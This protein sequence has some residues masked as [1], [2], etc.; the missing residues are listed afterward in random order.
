MFTRRVKRMARMKRMTRLKRMA[1]LNGWSIAFLAFAAALMGGCEYPYRSMRID[2]QEAVLQSD[3]GRAREIFM[4]CHDRKPNDAENLHDVGAMSYV[5]G[6]GRF[7]ERNAPAGLRECDRAIDFYGR[8]IMARP[9]YPAAIMGR[10]AAFELKGQF[11]KALKQAEWASRFVGPMARQYI[12]LAREHEDRGDM[13]LA[14][15]RYR[16]AV[17]LE[18]DNPEAHQAYGEFLQR[19]N[20]HDEASVE[21]REAERLYAMKEMPTPPSLQG[22]GGEPQP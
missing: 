6:E 13:D 3:Y 8:A 18:P 20:L 7:K 2:G 15:L 4:K 21:L 10:T 22:Q 14:R 5:I 19:R 9:N 11:E 17:V 1:R 12:F 16:Q